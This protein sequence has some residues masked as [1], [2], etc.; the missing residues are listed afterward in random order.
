MVAIDNYGL[1]CGLGARRKKSAGLRKKKAH[2]KKN[3]K[4][5]YIIENQYYSSNKT[6]LKAII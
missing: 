4:Y 5:F 2:N 6:K 3:L 1:A